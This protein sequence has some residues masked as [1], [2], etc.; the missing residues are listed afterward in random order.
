[1][2]LGIRHIVENLKIE[3][4]AV[5]GM[6]EAPLVSEGRFKQTVST[7][8]YRAESGLITVDFMEVWSVITIK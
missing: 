3:W 2:R 4:Y 8:S 1:M 7:S 6:V 5:V